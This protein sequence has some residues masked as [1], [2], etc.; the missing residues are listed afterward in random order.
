MSAKEKIIK[1]FEQA[2]KPLKSGEVAE[3]S[4]LEKNEVDKEIKKLTVSGTLY[5]P[6]R[7]FYDIKK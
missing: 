1:A 5:S 2:G 4:G 6:K 7:C 3:L